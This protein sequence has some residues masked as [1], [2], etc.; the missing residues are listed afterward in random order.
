[1]RPGR[2]AT[3]AVA[4]FALIFLVLALDHDL[5]GQDPGESIGTVSTHGELILIE[6]DPGVVVPAN[7]FD[8]EGRTLRFTPVGEGYEVANLPL[9]WEEEFGEELED[10]HVRLRNFAFPFSGQE[11]RSFFVNQHGTIGFAGGSPTVGRFAEMREGAPLIIDTD[12]A[13]AAFLKTRMSGPRFARELEDRAVVTWEL[14]EPYGGVHDYHFEPTTTRVQAVLHRDGTI[15][16]SYHEVDPEDAIVGVFAL[17]RS[18]ARQ[19]VTRIPLETNPHVPGHLDLAEVS[20]SLYDGFFLEV[21]LHTR[22][23]LL[24]PGHPGVVDRAYRVHIHR[25]AP[26]AQAARGWAYAD[27]AD[28]VWTVSADPDDGYVARG[29]GASGRVRVEGRTLSVAGHLPDEFTGA[30]RLHISVDVVGGERPLAVF[31]LLPP[32]EIALPPL[33]GKVTRLAEGTVGEGPRTVLFETFHHQSRPATADMACTVIEALGDHFHFLTYYSDFR[34]D[35]QEGSTPSTG[36]IGS[37]LRGIGTDGRR[38][39]EGMCSEGRLEVTYTQPV[40][41]DAVYGHERAPDGS[42]ENYDRIMSLM[43]HE[44]G[45]RWSA[46]LTVEMDGRSIPLGPSHWRAGLH[47]PAAHPYGSETESSTMGGS[48]WQE[49]GDGTYTQLDRDFFVPA[50]GFSHLELYL[51]GL[52]PPSEVPE[53]MVLENLARVGEDHDGYPVFL[54]DPLRFTI[55]DVIASNGIRLPR[56]PRTHF[57]TGV[58]GFVLPGEEPSELLLDRMEGIRRAW[59]HY[60]DVVTGGRLTVTTYPGPVAVE[61][62][63]DG[64][65]RDDPWQRRGGTPPEQGVL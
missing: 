24:S 63:L 5:H 26:H 25:E 15:E 42:F 32:E 4:A 59:I 51:M 54:G 53:M 18:G 35:Q 11:W 57:N 33:R 58:V 55:E 39:P 13:I 1:M 20:V 46:W 12:P 31:D 45:H 60:W 6:L 50:K 3:H 62:E 27:E 22:E 65:A 29:P 52:L 44:I 2:S 9:E 43:S 8:M 28:L 14:T 10:A 48:Y 61:D 37:E 49:N 38:A 16:L 36:A 64:E 47:A 40:Y 41:I 34:L 21:D 30:T 23:P 56:E 7:L 19:E 17:P